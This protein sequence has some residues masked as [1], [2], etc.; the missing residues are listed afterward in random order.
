MKVI[1]IG[2]PYFVKK[3]SSELSDFDKV[4]CYVGLD[5]SYRLSD[6][7]RYV[8]HILNTDIVYK[9]GGSARKGGALGLAFFLRKKI[10]VMWAGTDVLKSGRLIRNR[11]AD[12]A[13]INYCRHACE[14]SWIQYELKELNIHADILYTTT[15]D[16]SA[17]EGEI[18]LPETFSILTYVDQARED[19]F[20]IKTI[21][22]LA[23]DFPDVTVNIVGS[24]KSKYD[25]PRNIRLHGWVGNMDERYK[26]CTVFL[27]LPE[28]DGL[29]FS[30]LEALSFGRYVARTFPFPATYHAR[31]Y[32]VLRDFIAGLK[33]RHVQGNLRLNYEG[34]EF[35]KN[36]F[37][38]SKILKGFINYLENIDIGN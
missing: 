15:F 28:H 27:R 5:T 16:S 22:E 2:L 33:K 32:N 20:G 36:N 29:A 8:F 7:F 34:I 4:N 31:D 10:I 23:N 37:E 35:I 13:F 12:L 18:P 25:M 3:L 9:I 19:F 14:T 21:I 17:L 24:G 38:K 6:K 1:L 11:E 30:V 26:N